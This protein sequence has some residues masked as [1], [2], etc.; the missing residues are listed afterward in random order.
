MEG[1]QSGLNNKEV[2]SAIADPPLAEKLLCF[3]ACVYLLKSLANGKSYTGSTHKDDPI[4]RL[5]SHN[6]GKVKSTK[7]GRPWELI[8]NEKFDNYTEARKKELFFK[9]GKGRELL[10]NIWRDVRVDE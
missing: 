1:C 7:S 6:N 9:T 3:M 4:K 8:Y 5:Q 10:K 2:L